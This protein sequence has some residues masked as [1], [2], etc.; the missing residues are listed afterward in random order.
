MTLVNRLSHLLQDPPP[1][2]VFELSEAGI[3]WVRANSASPSFE[4]LEPGVLAISPLSDNVLKPETLTEKIRNVAGQ[5]SRKRRRA[6]VILPDFCARVAVLE[7]ASFP[8]DPKEQL[9]LVKFRMKKN[10]P[11]DVESAAISYFAQPNKGSKRLDVVVVVSALEIVARYEAPFRAAGLHPG[12]VTTS[13]ISMTELAQ[14]PGANV[15]A[16]LNGRVLTVVALSAGVLRLVRS[17]ELAD[18]SHDDI[19]AVLFPTI[20][21]VEDEMAVQPSH[22]FHCGF[23]DDVTSGWQT[24]LNVP[25]AA[26]R[27]R[28]GAP[29]QH[30]AGLLGYLDSMV[31]R[32]EARVA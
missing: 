22:L 11:F 19:M 16:R 15:I 25:V 8:A 3:A 13:A 7:F 23:S 10:V 24:E 31:Q 17:V 32:G 27:S 6:V 9:S 2:F 4:P 29:G 5:G 21:Y 14:D 18:V 20:A 26:L 30:N 28:F 12:I 1:D